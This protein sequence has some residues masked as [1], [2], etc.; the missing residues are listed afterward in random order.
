LEIL[1]FANPVCDIQY[2]DEPTTSPLVP[3]PEA[4]SASTIVGASGPQPSSSNTVPMVVESNE[5]QSL[6]NHIQVFIAS[7]TD[8]NRKDLPTSSSFIAPP[9]NQLLERIATGGDEASI[10][11]A[12]DIARVK[13]LEVKGEPLGE[14][15]PGVDFG[16]AAGVW[17]EPKLEDVNP[18]LGAS[19]PKPSV[20]LPTSW[21]SGASGLTCS[22]T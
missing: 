18:I 4:D 2:I 8:L 6:W 7:L 12:I 20:P 17:L 1:Y 22:W 10:G 13:L 15:K 11:K 3:L 5:P 9:V 16:V 19:G 21:L 14:E